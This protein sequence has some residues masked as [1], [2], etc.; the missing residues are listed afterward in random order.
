MSDLFGFPLS[1]QDCLVAIMVAASAADENIGTEELYTIEGIVD[2]LP[3]FAGYDQDRIKMIS[4]IVFDLFD[5]VDGL[6]A[7]FG[8]IRENLPE[9]LN[10]TAYALSCDVAGADGHLRENELRFLEEI[11]HEL[12]IDRLHA[13]AIER[14]ARARL[15][16]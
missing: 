2:H 7:L 3:I 1:P 9:R 11:R 6:D 8:I 13:A 14:G 12:A 5:Q 15:I 4:Q 16:R 10:E